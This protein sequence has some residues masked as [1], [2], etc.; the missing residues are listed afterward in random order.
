[1]LSRVVE[2]IRRC[3]SPRRF[4]RARPPTVLL[5]RTSCRAGFLLRMRRSRWRAPEDR[6]A[7]VPSRRHTAP[8][9]T[10]SC[11]L[12]RGDFDSADIR[13]AF[14]G[15][16]GPVCDWE[17]PSGCRGIRMHGAQNPRSSEEGVSPCGMRDDLLACRLGSPCPPR[18]SNPLVNRFREAVIIVEVEC[19]CAIP[20]VV[21]ADLRAGGDGRPVGVRSNSYTLSSTSG[22][23]HSLASN[24]FRRGTKA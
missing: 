5:Q 24:R 4:E 16:R 23:S 22:G 2:P 6:L 1:M 14:A 13:S 7:A 10:R 18:L 8:G 19:L 17:G 21:H 20:P 12:H 3:G 11:L 15:R 9:R